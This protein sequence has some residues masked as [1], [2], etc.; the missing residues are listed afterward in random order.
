MARFGWLGS[1]AAAC[2]T[3]FAAVTAAGPPPSGA[4][5]AP[6]PT[7]VFTAPW[8][9]GV[10]F[11]DFDGDGVRDILVDELSGLTLYFMTATGTV[12]ASV[13]YSGEVLPPSAPLDQLYLER[14][15]SVGIDSADFTGDGRPEVL[16][17]EETDVRLLRVSTSG[18]EFLTDMRAMD[19]VPL[20]A[21]GRFAPGAA[22][23]LVVEPSHDT[24]PFELAVLGLSTD[25]LVETQRL[26][27]G[28][29]I[30]KN[31]GGF[32]GHPMRVVDLNGDGRDDLVYPGVDSAIVRLQAATGGFGTAT[33]LALGG[34]LASIAAADFDG[35]GRVDLAISAGYPAE[36]HTFLQTT[37]G[38]F[39]E[40]GTPL[41]S[42]YPLLAAD[43]DG[44]GSSEL[45]GATAVLWWDAQAWATGEPLETGTSGIL[46]SVED[47]DGDGLLDLVVSDAVA[48]TV[49]E[50]ELRILR[51]QQA[52]LSVTFVDSTEAIAGEPFEA[53]FELRNDG[54]SPTGP[55]VATITGT[56]SSRAE[57]VSPECTA[58]P[59]EI[60]SLD[61]GQTSR[62]TVRSYPSSN[63]T[64]QV[65]I[66]V[67]GATWDSDLSDNA[68]EVSV[69]VS[70]RAD[71]SGSMSLWIEDTTI[72][73]P[74]SVYN[75]GPSLAEGVVLVLQLPDGISGVSWESDPPAS[76]S[77]SGLELTCELDQL[78]QSWS[79]DVQGRFSYHNQ[80]VETSGDVSS[81]I[82]DPDPSNNHFGQVLPEDFIAGLVG[83]PGSED[84]GGCG[85]SL[86]AKR[87]GA[88]A[89]L[90]IA[91]IAFLTRLVRRARSLRARRSCP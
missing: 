39:V 81:P 7:R 55:I 26:A 10:V 2:I 80:R 71:L 56:E 35:D 12:R 29:I 16:L 53:T 4:L 37:S 59:C 49:A 51:G 75:S 70:P 62:V 65:A 42:S 50:G 33:Q 73:L 22:E 13:S 87:P 54:P 79:I 68:A 91:A 11:D 77:E 84:D 63:T 36:L 48:V 47:W 52:G 40:T 19:F 18:F 38:A 66:S 6:E 46:Q 67:R 3:S 60:P 5:F 85:C 43:L 44:D 86:G 8:L 64:E 1:A 78:E 90:L 30:G 83:G 14:V 88:P 24:E 72:F 82:I 23:Q 57:Q 61:A 28:G 27:E 32:A 21:T 34:D 25:T 31:S 17:V 89:V 76:C 15:D 9:Y 58:E 41:P 74:T 45:V 69:S 20:T